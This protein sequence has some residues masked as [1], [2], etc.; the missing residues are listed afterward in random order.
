MGILELT[1]SDSVALAFHDGDIG[2]VGESVEQCSDTGG[3]GEHGVP[4]FESKIGR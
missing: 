3:V 2:M 1:F 4:V